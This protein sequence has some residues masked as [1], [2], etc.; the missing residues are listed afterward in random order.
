M[1]VYLN[2]TYFNKWQAL[3]DLVNETLY[4]SYRDPSYLF[5]DANGECIPIQ[6]RCDGVADCADGTDEQLCVMYDCS[7]DQYKCPST[8]ECI[9]KSWLCDGGYDCQDYSDEDRTVCD[10]Y[11]AYRMWSD[12]IRYS[13]VWISCGIFIYTIKY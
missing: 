12:C 11:G 6:W 9:P 4:G 7:T 10:K 13:L 2:E 5:E 1:V 3:Y 8:G